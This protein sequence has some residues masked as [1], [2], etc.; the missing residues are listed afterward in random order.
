MAPTRGQPPSA[1]SLIGLLFRARVMSP[2]A[3]IKRHA[4][5][6][7]P[8][9]HVGHL[10]TSATCRRPST[11]SSTLRRTRP[12]ILGVPWCLLEDSNHRT[13]E[14]DSARSGWTNNLVVFTPDGQYLGEITSANSCCAAD[15]LPPTPGQRDQPVPLAPPVRRDQRGERVDYFL[16]GSRISLRSGLDASIGWAWFR[17]RTRGRWRESFRS[18][19]CRVRRERWW[20]SG[21]GVAELMRRGRA[22]RGR[23][24]MGQL[25]PPTRRKPECLSPTSSKAT[26]SGERPGVAR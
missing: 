18:V 6:W 12:G 13:Q 19:P 23:V 26:R 14:L 11:R 25:A 17:P 5:S 10:A 2:P 16:Q 15:V 9:V 4:H 3:G 21:M 7:L 24:V 8:I 1:R 22:I 20:G